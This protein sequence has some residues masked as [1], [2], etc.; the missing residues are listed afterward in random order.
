[1][2]EPALVPGHAFTIAGVFALAALFLGSCAGFD[3]AGSGAGKL[4]TQALYEEQVEEGFGKIAPL[5]INWSEP[6]SRAG[7]LAGHW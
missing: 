4:M 6:A 7:S 3:R 2:T 5:P 1:M